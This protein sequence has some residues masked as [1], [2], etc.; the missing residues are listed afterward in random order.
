MPVDREGPIH[1]A[2]LAYLRAVLPDA[3]VHH[4]ANEIGLSGAHVARQIAK[5]KRL[6]QVTGW[7]DLIVIPCSDIGPMFFEVK[8]PG[9]YPTRAQTDLHD[10]LRRLGY[11]VG[12]VR[13]VDDTRAIL[14]AWGVVTREA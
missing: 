7:P 10:H 5:A 4:G 13:S 8:A 2:I 11:R 1:R 9:G 12:L 6:G 14:A 3:I